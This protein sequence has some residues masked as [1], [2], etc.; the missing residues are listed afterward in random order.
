VYYDK[1]KSQLSRFTIYWIYLFL[2]IGLRV[3]YGKTRR[4]QLIA[5]HHFQ[6]YHKIK[7]IR[8]SLRWSSAKYGYDDWEPSVSEFLKGITGELFVD[9]GASVGYY[10]L[11]LSSNFDEVIAVEPETNSANKLRKN[12]EHLGNVRVVQEAVSDEDGETT[13]FVSP[14]IGWHSITPQNTG[15]Y[16]PTKI[17]TITLETL[18]GGKTASLIKVDTE[19]AELKIIDGANTEQIDSWLVEAHGGEER[20]TA[21]E[22]KLTKMGYEVK[23][24]T[25]S[26]IFAYNNDIT[27]EISKV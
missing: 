20:K 12:T 22:T 7:Q 25:P 27:A 15:S 4:D 3:R 26:H 13:L 2:R 1:I 5:I 10:T 9:V 6:F 8:Y 23:W 11:L 19:G 21:L 24:I 17:R 18:L 14:M 16:T